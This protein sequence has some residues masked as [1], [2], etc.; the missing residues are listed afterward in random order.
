MPVLRP[1]VLSPPKSLK[2][3]LLQNHINRVL[4]LKLQ[5][6]QMNASLQDR[7]SNNST[8]HSSKASALVYLDPS[9]GI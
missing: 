8:S 6:M 7:S 2:N 1:E 9:G 3:H 5:H 4:A